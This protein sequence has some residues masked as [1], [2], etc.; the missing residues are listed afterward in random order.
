[1][2]HDAGTGAAGPDVPEGEPGGRPTT[3]IEDDGVTWRFDDTFLTSRWTCL[4]GRGCLGILEEPAPELGQGCCSVGAVLD[5][6]DEAMRVSALADTLDPSVFQFHDDAAAGGIFAPGIEAE[7][8]PTAT[9]VAAARGSPDGAQAS[10][11]GS[12]PGRE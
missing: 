8:A 9:R 2:A 12:S 6:V 7:G 3:E 1:M 11:A 5:G 10:E 4:W